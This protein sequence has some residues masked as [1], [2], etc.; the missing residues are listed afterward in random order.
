M[1]NDKQDALRYRVLKQFLAV[2]RDSPND[3]TCWLDLPC[4]PFRSQTEEPDDLVDKLVE[5]YLMNKAY[6]L[7]KDN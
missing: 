7:K 1:D 2:E 5:N 3:W 4:I 6:E